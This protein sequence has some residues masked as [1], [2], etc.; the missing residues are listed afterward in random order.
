[1]HKNL[2]MTQKYLVNP[3]MFNDYHQIL[4]TNDQNQEYLLNR[5]KGYV[6]KV[7]KNK[8]KP[9]DFKINKT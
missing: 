2:Q 7:R 6:W 8:T 4:C 9:T 5:N 1:M 3:L